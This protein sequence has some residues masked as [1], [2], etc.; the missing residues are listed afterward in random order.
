AGMLAPAFESALE[1]PGPD[2]FAMLAASRDLWAETN[3]E[4]YRDGALWI[5]LAGDAQPVAAALRAQGARAELLSPAEARRLAPGLASDVDGAVFTPED[6]RLEPPGALAAL[7]QTYLDLGGGWV[8]ASAQAVSAR[9]VQTES[10]RLQADAVVVCTGYAAAPPGGAPELAS[11]TAIRGE[12]VRFPGQAPERGPALRH[13]GGYIVPSAAGPIAGATMLAGV[14]SL[15]PSSAA[16]QQAEAA[17]VILPH[18]RSAP[19][20]PAVGVRAATPDGLPLAGRSASGVWLAAGFRRN[21][22]LLAPLAARIIAAGL[23]G[24][25]PGPWA[26]ALRPDRFAARPSRA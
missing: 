1:A 13:A 26:E 5:S 2:G 6:W 25:D 10:E 22:W 3:V 4:L 11:L 20:S 16:Q 18:L 17:A 9:S 19:F 21:G 8:V 14:E 12:L 23:G 15:E 7:R 24:A